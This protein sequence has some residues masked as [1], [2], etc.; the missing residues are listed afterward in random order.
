MAMFVELR[1]GET[2]EIGKAKITIEAKSGSRSRLRIDSLDDVRVQRA[3]DAI[4]DGAGSAPT[5]PS[6]SPSP[7]HERNNNKKPQIDVPLLTI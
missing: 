3:D 5:A 2:V 1:P 6:P 7:Q 4:R